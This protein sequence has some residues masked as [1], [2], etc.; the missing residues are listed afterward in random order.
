MN[1]LLDV[2]GLTPFFSSDYK[3][4]F[5]L[6]SLRKLGHILWV[7]QFNYRCDYFTHLQ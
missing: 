4:N 1:G 6:S 5:A 7:V 2:Q 3:I